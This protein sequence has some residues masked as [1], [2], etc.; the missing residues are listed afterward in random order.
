MA[1]G[2]AV[3]ITIFLGF[4]TS[5]QI[6]VTITASAGDRTPSKLSKTIVP[7]VSSVLSSS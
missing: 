2:R 1:D 6:T 3:P 7:I 4:E 5:L